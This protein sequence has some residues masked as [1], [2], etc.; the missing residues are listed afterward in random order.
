MAIFSTS[1]NKFVHL[2]LQNTIGLASELKGEQHVKDALKAGAEIVI[3]G[4]NDFY[5][6]RAKVRSLQSA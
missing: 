2:A 1:K 3:L 6:Q 5:S 4:D